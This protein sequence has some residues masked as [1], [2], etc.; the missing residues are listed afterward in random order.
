MTIDI[1]LVVITV[2]GFIAAFVN[3]A[4]ATGGVYIVLLSSISVLPITAAIQLQAAFSASSL[5]GRVFFFWK[6]IDWTIVSTFA[7]GC[8]VGVGLGTVTFANLPDQLISIL[9]GFVLLLMIWLPK[10]PKAPRLKR[11]FMY[12]GVVHSYISAIFGV[13][14]ILQPAI[15]RTD[16]RKDVITGTL[17]AC[18]VAMEAMKVS[19]YLSIGFNYANYIPHIICANIA[20]VLGVWAG[21][22]VTHLISEQTFR[23]FFKIFV[24]LVA[25]RL[26]WR[27]LIG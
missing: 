27:G 5:F 12:I 19:G 13:G 10:L 18:M 25:L 7:L 4:F 26:I 24:S 9:L 3:A 11:P 22:R 17:A 14:G 2:G 21:K 6:D 16:L 23:T 15:L 20:G 1:T 8:L